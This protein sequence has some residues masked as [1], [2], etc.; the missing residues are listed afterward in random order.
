VHNPAGRKI[1]GVTWGPLH[2]RK[3]AGWSPIAL[4]R[5]SH[6]TLILKPVRW[7]AWRP[8]WWFSS[9]QHT[10]MFLLTLP[11]YRPQHGITW[12]SWCKITGREALLHSGQYTCRMRIRWPRDIATLRCSMKHIFTRVGNN[13]T[14]TGLN[15]VMKCT[16]VSGVLYACLVI[17]FFHT[18]FL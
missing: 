8:A 12:N 3:V 9:D 13:K 7:W 6:H 2:L 16:K 11:F 5:I 4:L 14:D 18:L 17:A 1:N 10:T 15:T